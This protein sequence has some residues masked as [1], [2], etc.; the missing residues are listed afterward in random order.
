MQAD[1]PGEKTYDSIL[2]RTAR[3]TGVDFAILQG[4]I[5]KIKDIPYGQLI[6]RLEGESG[7]I[8][9]TIRKVRDEGLDVEVYD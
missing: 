5:S 6:V 9:E 1:V 3:E 7:P 8:E 4:T 2:S